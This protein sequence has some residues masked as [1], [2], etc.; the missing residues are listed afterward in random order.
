VSPGTDFI[1]FPRIPSRRVA[2][3]VRRAD[4]VTENFTAGTA[5]RL[6]VGYEVVR[7]VNQRI[8]YCSI[9]GFGGGT[10]TRGF[11]PWIP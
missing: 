11:E 4:V 5:D 7:Q 6:A 1:G 2:H 8:V 10:L 3:L 9:S